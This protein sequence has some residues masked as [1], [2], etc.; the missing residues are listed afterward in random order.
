VCR[1]EGHA[2]QPVARLPQPVAPPTCHDTPASPLPT[3]ATHRSASPRPSVQVGSR[4]PGTACGR[5]VTSLPT[6]APEQLPSTAQGA[7]CPARPLVS[8]AA[9]PGQRHRQWLTPFWGSRAEVLGPSA[10][11]MLCSDGCAPR[12]PLGDAA[13]A[14]DMLR[15]AGARRAAGGGREGCAAVLRPLYVRYDTYCH[16][17]VRG[18]QR[19]RHPGPCGGDLAGSRTARRPPPALPPPPLTEGGAEAACLDLVDATRSCGATRP[20][21]L[22][23]AQPSAAHAPLHMAPWHPRL[24]HSPLRPSL[25]HGPRTRVDARRSSLGHGA[26]ARHRAGGHR[27]EARAHV[28]W[29]GGGTRRRTG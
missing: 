10:R 19:C 29:A 25:P 12:R 28:L 21:R 8:A 7:G 20:V 16:T 3:P 18:A 15:T 1:V 17:Q 9:A 6:P 4:L 13:L 22:G 2:K 27:L 26:D 24:A 14:P 5:C 11:L 23:H